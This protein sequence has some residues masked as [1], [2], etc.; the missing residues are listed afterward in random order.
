MVLLMVQV[1][2]NLAVHKEGK[3]VKIREEYSTERPKNLVRFLQSKSLYENGQDFLD[4][5]YLEA[6][7]NRGVDTDT[8]CFGQYS[9]F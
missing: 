9:C 6:L 2:S 7:L 8:N 1:K 4:R 5:Q 3:Y